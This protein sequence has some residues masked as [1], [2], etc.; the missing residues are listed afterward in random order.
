MLAAGSDVAGIK[1]T[2]VRQGDNYLVNGSKKWITNAIWA[3]Y[4]TAAVRS[5][6]PGA[7]GVSVLIIP[8]KAP[9]VSTR[10]MFNSGVGA[11]GSTYITF[12][13]VLVWSDLSALCVDVLNDQLGQECDAV[14][15][16]DACEPSEWNTTGVEPAACCRRTNLGD[17][18]LIET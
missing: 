9:G 5:G 12:E 6:G 4:V 11:S 14:V 10:K 13:D 15:R 7:G 18:S 3:D 2:A 17:C 1:T 16:L 8:L